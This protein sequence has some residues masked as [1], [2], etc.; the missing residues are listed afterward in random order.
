MTSETGYWGDR[1]DSGMRNAQIGAQT[2]CFGNAADDAGGVRG[3][4]IARAEDV[5]AF[6]SGHRKPSL[7]G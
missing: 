4:V 5:G 6:H 2:N 3:I 7:H 1:T